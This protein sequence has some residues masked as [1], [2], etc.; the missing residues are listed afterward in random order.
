MTFWT[1]FAIGEATVGL[2]VWVVAVVMARR[3]W[4]QLR[5]ALA[6]YLAMLV[7]PEEGQG[8]DDVNIAETFGL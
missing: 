4:Q 8:E 3:A 1:W 6:P 7:P 2:L 5:P